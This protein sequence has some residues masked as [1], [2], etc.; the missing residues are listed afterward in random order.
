[1]QQPTLAQNVAQKTTAFAH[2]KHTIF[3]PRHKAWHTKTRSCSMPHKDQMPLVPTLIPFQIS[4]NDNNNDND[5]PEPPNLPGKQQTALVAD[6]ASKQPSETR[7]NPNRAKP[8]MHTK[9][10]QFLFAHDNPTNQRSQWV[11]N[12]D[13]QPLAQ[14]QQTLWTATP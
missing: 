4:D 9:R 14:L 11:E 8:R 13:M 10:T 5:N 12:N 2:P 6:C 1:M 3:S 7:T